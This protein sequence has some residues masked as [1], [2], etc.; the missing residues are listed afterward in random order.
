MLY[1]ETIESATLALIKKLS[2]DI[3]LKDFVLVGGTALALQFGHRKSID[4]D[5]FNA[6]SFD[7][8]SIG[9]HIE[10]VYDG[11]EIAV[12]QNAVF[13]YIEGV[14]TD[15]VSLPYSWVRP[16]VETQGIRMASPEDLA[17]TKFNAIV[18][19]G[20]RLK[21]YIDIFYLLEHANLDHWLG[22]YAE[23][24]SER[25]A[26]IA[27]NALLYHVEIKFDVE[28]N[29]LG[30]EFNWKEMVQ[31]FNAAVVEPKRVFEVKKQPSIKIPKSD[32]DGPSQRVGKGRR[33]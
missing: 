20:R 9:R 28:L 32:E 11:K 1:E 30:R 23:R 19:S 12:L 18:E 14:K 27:K 8:L 6:R 33:K 3:Q 22:A 7:P 5:L 25:N 17:A 2:A 16:L 29:L 24:Y 26:A 13:S 31:R 10:S 15:M 4:I 21:D